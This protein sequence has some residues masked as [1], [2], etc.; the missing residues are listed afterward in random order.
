MLFYFVELQG[1]SAGILGENSRHN[2]SRRLFR[3][4]VACF[5][6]QRHFHFHGKKKSISFLQVL[7]ELVCNMVQIISVFLFPKIFCKGNT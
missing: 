6:G 2:R 4:L 3:R 7:M 5:H 1:K